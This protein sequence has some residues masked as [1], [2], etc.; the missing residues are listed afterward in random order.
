MFVTICIPA[1]NEEQHIAFTLNSV[2]D[3]IKQVPNHQIDILVCANACT[4]TTVD[5]VKEWAR[6]N[7]FVLKIHN[8]DNSLII[9]EQSDKDRGKLHITVLSTKV[10]GKPNA[11][12]NLHRYVKSNILIFIDADVVIHP[13]AFVFLI[14]TLINHSEIKAAGG[15]VLAPQVKGLRPLYRKMAIKMK[16]FATKDT[17]YINGPLYAIRKGAIKNIPEEIIHEDAYIGMRLGVNQIV[18]VVDAIAFQVPPNTYRD[19]YKRQM[20]NKIADFQLKHLYGVKYSSFRKDTQDNRTKKEREGCLTKKEK[21]LKRI[22]F[23]Q[24]WLL[25]ILDKIAKVQAKKMFDRGIVR[26]YT[27]PSTKQKIN[28]TKKI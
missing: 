22:L 24:T 4:D 14:Q 5:K 26:W 17:P 15:I 25:K 20:R 13:M 1:H 8:L 7:D 2:W 19:Y 23:L 11:W 6:L 16:E 12:N 21:I 10:P 27:I 28:G 18:K 9:E 3:A